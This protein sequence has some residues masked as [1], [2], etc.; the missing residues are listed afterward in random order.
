MNR[1]NV[2]GNHCGIP[3]GNANK[4]AVWKG[5]NLNNLL[6]FRCSF[7]SLEIASELLAK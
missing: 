6:Y 4:F 7:P 5:D 3:Q 1:Q 2:L